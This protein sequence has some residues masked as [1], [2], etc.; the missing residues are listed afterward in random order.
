M[1]TYETEDEV[2]EAFW[3]ASL[4]DANETFIR[5]HERWL[6]GATQNQLPTDVRCA[7]VDFVDALCK[8]GQ[9]TADLADEVTL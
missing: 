8:D 5:A 1:L 3:Q 2:R 6:G 4:A 9:I 7:W